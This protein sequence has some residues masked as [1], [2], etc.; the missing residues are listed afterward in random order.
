MRSLLIAVALG[1]LTQQPTFRSRVDLVRI[2][3][4]VVDGQGRP[5]RDLEPEDFVVTV[6][7][8]L[9]PVAF[10]QFYGSD[11]IP[12]Q[13]TDVQ[14]VSVATNQSFTP[15][16]VI[17][18]VV[19]LES[20]VPGAEKPALD[21]VG[22]LVESLGPSDAV[23][24]LVLPGRSVEVTRDHAKVR[25]ALQGLMGA[26]APPSSRYQMS[27]R[28]AE[29]FRTRDQRIIGQ[30]V[31]RECRPKDMTCPRE[32]ADMAMPLLLE[33]DRRTQS[34][35]PALTRLFTRLSAIEAPRSVVLL[36]AGLQRTNGSQ[37]FFNDLQRSAD[38]AGV[39]MTVVQIE[40]P[41]STASRRTAAGGLSRSDLTDGLSSV[42]GATGGE[43]YYAVGRATGA[44]DRIRNEIVH[45]YELGIES[46]ASDADGKKHRVKV[47]VK[48]GGVTVRARK[49]FAI[50]TEPQT[51]LNPVDV[52]SQP[53]DFAEAPMV[54][55]T[56]MTRGEET[57][58]LKTIIVVE[59]L[60]SITGE[61][62]TSYAITISDTAGKA[63][64][65]TAARFAAGRSDAAIATQLAPGRY[66]LRAALVDPAGR[67]GSLE[68]PIL[69]GLR[70]VGTLQLSDLIVG[71]TGATFAAAS[72][73]PVGTP[74]G[75]LLELYSADPAQFEGVTVVAEVRRAGATA[76]AARAAAEPRKTDLDRRRVAVAEFPAAALTPGTWIVSAVVRRGEAT[77][78]QVSRTLVIEAARDGASGR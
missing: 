66:R 11:E 57:A 15:G 25:E 44:F 60:G 64:F 14:T 69:V 51:S 3:V 9:R 49:E 4:T 21:T 53:V 19:D 36:S 76:P 63:V 77:I 33:A 41:E 54:V 7:G 17:V 61:P 26:A 48:R 10:A 59:T 38:T 70:Q 43:M 28:E 73:I 39:R 71:R 5:V 2:D 67:P 37:G 65:E 74:A 52:L 22:S 32:L 40:Q 46:S 78:G 13:S 35:V 72:R 23:G 34:L 50:S 68:M 31:E 12:R 1:V 29:A 47:E 58:T 27:V 30:V 6:D 20:I 56:Y 24:L 42:A 8:A 62:L 75:A 45:S 55:S 18:L 16:R